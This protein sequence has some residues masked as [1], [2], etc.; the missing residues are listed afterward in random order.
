MGQKRKEASEQAVTVAKR[1]R[2]VANANFRMESKLM[3]DGLTSE[4]TFLQAERQ[5][6]VAKAEELRAKLA[7]LAAQEEVEALSADVAKVGNDASAS[8]SSAKA[9]KQ[10]AEAEVA[11]AQRDLED[12]KIRIARQETQEVTAPCDGTVFRILA[13]CATGGSFVKSGERLLVL[14]PEI[15]GK[16]KRTVELFFDGND[17][18]QV[19]TYMMQTL[20]NPEAPDIDV[21]L[22][23]EGWPAIQTIGWPNLAR[24]TFPGKVVFVD[25]HDDGKGRFRVLVEPDADNPDVWPSEFELRQGARAKGWVLLN[26]V[27]LGYEM[28]RRFN[29]FPPVLDS[30]E[31]DGSRKKPEKVRVPK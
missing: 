24:G 16:R 31:K 22:Q 29:G 2:D 15:K 11:S 1:T 8:I 18:P 28:W 25:Q 9:S 21:R 12:M 26:E 13:N 6:D 27:P 19:M 17:A 10:S 5:K 4:L 7:L 20:Q 23:F 30:K 3:N 14:V